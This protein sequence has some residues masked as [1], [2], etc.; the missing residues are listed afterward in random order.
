[1]SEKGVNLA[2]TRGMNIILYALL[3]SA[4]DIYVDLSF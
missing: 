2:D 4:H 3:Y 1:M